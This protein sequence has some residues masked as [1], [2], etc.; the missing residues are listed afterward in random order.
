MFKNKLHY[1]KIFNELIPS[2]KKNNFIKFS[3]CVDI[4]KFFKDI[5]FV[6]FESFSIISKKKCTKNQV[7]DLLGDYILE[8]YFLSKKF[9][10]RLTKDIYICR[11]I[12]I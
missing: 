11:N 7:I 1:K 5:E 2:S 10:K 6:D 9:N 3:E 4:E 12:S 8:S